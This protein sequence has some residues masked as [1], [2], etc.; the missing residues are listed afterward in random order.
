[1][2]VVLCICADALESMAL[3]NLEV[4]KACVSEV[5]SRLVI[6]VEVQYCFHSWHFPRLSSSG[7]SA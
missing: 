6:E 1:M 5:E 2:Q 4:M 3:N 7:L